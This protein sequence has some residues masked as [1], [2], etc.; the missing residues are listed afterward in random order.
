MEKRGIKKGTKRGPY[1]RAQIKKAQREVQNDGLSHHQIALLLEIPIGEVK[2]IEQQA[3]EKLK[4]PTGINKIFH[5]YLG[6]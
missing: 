6:I 2:R 3:L 1:K 5:R 4:T